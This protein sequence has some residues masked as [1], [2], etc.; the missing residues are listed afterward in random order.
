MERE[1]PDSELI[2]LGTASADT[3]GSPIPTVAE[4][5]GYLPLGLSDG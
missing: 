2:E 1:A 4:D 3:H 5:N